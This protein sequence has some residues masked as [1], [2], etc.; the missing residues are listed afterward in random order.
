MS[1]NFEHGS[2]GV[3]ASYIEKMGGSCIKSVTK[4]CNYVVVGGCGNEMW[5]TGKYGSKVKKAMD[6][7]S[8]G[9]SIEIIGE[10]EL[11]M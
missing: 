10:N 8:K 7:Q 3:I 1:G 5:S 2:K 11:G 9:V 6:W 4:K